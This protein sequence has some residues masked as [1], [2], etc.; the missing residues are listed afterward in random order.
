[1]RANDIPSSQNTN[2]EHSSFL[3]NAD[4]I[5]RQSEGQVTN[6]SLTSLEDFV[7]SP[8]N[9]QPADAQYSPHRTA[10]TI[11]NHLANSRAFAQLLASHQEGRRASFPTRRRKKQISIQYKNFADDCAE[12]KSVRAN[13]SNAALADRGRK[14]LTCRNPVLAHESQA[15]R[16]F[17]VPLKDDDLEELRLENLELRQQIKQQRIIFDSKKYSLK[18]QKE[19]LAQEL[20]K[21]NTRVELLE[22]ENAQLAKSHNVALADASTCI[23]KGITGQYFKERGSQSK[24][25]M[26]SNFTQTEAESTNRVMQHLRQEVK[27]YISK[28]AKYKS[29]QAINKE[30]IAKLQRL[31]SICEAE[32]TDTE[33][34]RLAV[35]A[36]LQA[37][38]YKYDLDKKN[39][40][41]II[42][43]LRLKISNLEAENK[44]LG[45]ENGRL[46]EEIAIIDEQ[47]EML[48]EMTEKLSHYEEL[49]A[50][51]ARSSKDHKKLA[52]EYKQKL[53]D[54]E[55]NVGCCKD[56]NHKL[57]DK[58]RE[59]K[60]EAD[61]LKIDNL[62]QR[63][64]FTEKCK[65]YKEIRTE[66]RKKLK[67][68]DDMVLKLQKEINLMRNRRKDI[69][70]DSSIEP[71]I[72]DKVFSRPKSLENT[73]VHYLK[74]LGTTMQFAE[75]P[76][77]LKKKFEGVIEVTSKVTQ[78]ASERTSHNKGG[79]SHE[80]ISNV[81][82]N[83]GDKSKSFC[84]D[85]ASTGMCAKNVCSRISIGRFVRGEGLVGGQGAGVECG[86]AAMHEGGQKR[87]RQELRG[88]VR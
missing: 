14:S 76:I 52:E 37:T 20:A 30:L 32:K 12:P 3:S 40:S 24:V 44:V 26:K 45:E 55:R 80:R 60:S 82:A 64:F 61:R 31:L 71:E 77:K 49:Y 28:I 35:A 21:Y 57:L 9:S 10:I 79:I 19:A 51:F 8:E 62:K 83:A 66:L 75:L 25:V 47:P 11:P 18:C 38:K 15:S 33:K 85:E 86:Q 4:Q 17:A 46:K 5:L 54:A 84:F 42:S 13:H 65:G 81:N 29:E 50:R 1:M 16:S 59:L 58:I 23:D 70:H 2:S 7:D 27:S 34:R 36:H 43:E 68:K 53:S 48:K 88:R 63:Q 69:G 41:N 22:E 72:E 78:L 73:G 39:S 67:Q 6:E 74:D 87:G 56:E